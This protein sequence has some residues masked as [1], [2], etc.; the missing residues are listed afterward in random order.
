MEELHISTMT[1]SV[2][3]GVISILLALIAFF[4]AR[5]LIQ[6]DALQENFKELIN[7]VSR[8]D[9]D[10]SGDVGILKSRIE[11]YDPIWDRLR[12]TEL[13]IASIKSGGCEQIKQ[14]RTQ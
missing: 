3:G 7:T 1:I 11:E 10:L 2:V 9:K 6:F 8:I 14:C 12:K 5:L 4:L 13:D